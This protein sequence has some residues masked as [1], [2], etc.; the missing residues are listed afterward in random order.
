[1]ITYLDTILKVTLF[2]NCDTRGILHVEDR[3][4]SESY[5]V[6]RGALLGAYLAGGVSSVNLDFHS[7]ARHGET[8]NSIGIS[9]LLL[10]SSL[11]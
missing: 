7:E 6:S 3:S 4:G 5:I 11:E 9:W 10:V 1:V 8:Q 2:L